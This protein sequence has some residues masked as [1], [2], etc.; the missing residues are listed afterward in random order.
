MLRRTHLNQRGF[1][2]TELL[3]SSSIG[4]TILSGV[5][6]LYSSI[7]RGTFLMLSDAQLDWELH[8]ALHLM[9]RDLRRAGYWAGEPGK[10][11]LLENPFT[12]AENK[13]SIGAAR[14]E[15]IHSCVTFAYDRDK[16]KLLVRCTCVRCAHRIASSMSATLHASIPLTIH[17]M[18]KSTSACNAS[19][20]EA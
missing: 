14:N 8:S 9:I 19:I 1:T 16:D 3:I 20:V 15:A 11:P 6:L 12:T 10:D 18:G 5:I 2:I 4:L 17:S 7:V 13:L